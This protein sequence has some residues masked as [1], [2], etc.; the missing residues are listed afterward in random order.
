MKSWLIDKGGVYVLMQF[1]LFGVIILAPG[2]FVGEWSAP[3]ILIG[4]VVGGVLFVY[5]VLAIGGGMLRLGRNLRA[6][7]HP[8]D[9]ATLITSGFYRLV[10]HPIY[11]GIILGWTGWALFGGAELTALLVIGLLFPFFHIK[12]RREEQMLLARFPEYA[13]Y[14]ADVSKLMPY[15]Y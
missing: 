12:T 7:P 5:G 4:R 9:D 3:L 1:A 6:E 15:I 10:R 13:S 14:Q 8:T 2:K 11:S